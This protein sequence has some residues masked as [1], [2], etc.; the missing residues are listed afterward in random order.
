MS[1]QIF[2][3]PIA[4][5]LAGWLAELVRHWGKQ[6]F[7]ASWPGGLLAVGWGAHTF[8]LALE[9]VQTGLNPANLLSGAAWLAVILYY[10]ARR[11]DDA[12]TFRFIFPPFAIALLLTAAF[13]SSR[14][15]L[16]PEQVEFYPGFRRNLLTVHIITLLAGHLLFAMACLISSGYLYQERRLK[17]KLSGGGVS[18]LPSL[19]TLETLNHRAITLG[20]FLHSVG[21]LLGLLVA[22]AHN[23]PTRLLTGRLIIPTLTWLIYAT[24]LLEYHY[25]GRRGRFGAVWSIVGF[26]IAVMSMVFEFL[27]LFLSR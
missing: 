17:Q 7:A 26:F 18:R 16:Q 11:R 4:L 21:I 23:L 3:F 24:F 25:Q 15:L 5:Y 9:V 22:G 2:L 14:L 19:G 27:V 1:N 6:P 13:A 20:F 10:L 8:L 12:S